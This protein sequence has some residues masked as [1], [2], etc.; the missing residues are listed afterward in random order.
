MHSPARNPRAP[1]AVRNGC[2]RAIQTLWFEGLGLLIVA[3]LLAYFAGTTLGDSLQLLLL[4]AVVVTLWSALYNTAF[5]HIERRFTGRVASDRPPRWR[6]LHA[7]ALEASAL[8]LT[9]PLVV[10]LT[11]LSWRQAFVAEIG[12]TLAY[13]A[14]GY[15]F[16]LA[17]DHLRP[18]PPPPHRRSDS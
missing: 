12:L 18:V 16:H 3:P 9:W 8:V 17:F 7:I 6:V 15:C 14:Y 13:V 2:E 1:V 10:A 5:D 11:T 4:L